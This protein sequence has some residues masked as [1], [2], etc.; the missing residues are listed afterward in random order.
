MR[1]KVQGRLYSPAPKLN[2]LRILEQIG[3]NPEV[4]QSE[5]AQRCALSVAMVNNY[6]KDLA[7]RGLLEYRKKSCKTISYHLTPAGREA[8]ESIQNELLQELVELSADAREWVWGI[9][10]SQA[11]HELRRA[12]LY[13]NG[14]LGEIAF[15]ALESSGA[16]IVG[17]CGSDPGDVGKEWCGRE[18]VSA[19]Q[20]RYLAPDAVVV[21][22]EEGSDGV[23]RGLTHLA[24]HGI[25]VIRID[26]VPSRLLES[27]G[28]EFQAPQAALA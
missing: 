25:D 28:S 9:I 16:R 18:M 13:G 26:R 14:I 24:Q 20:I 7:D 5:M 3:Q 2:Q 6:M 12:V 10:L 1:T 27:G 4:T 22:L 15:H 11:R 17:V 8:V 21:A 19:S 23:C